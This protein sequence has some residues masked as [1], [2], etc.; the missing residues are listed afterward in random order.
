MTA[1]AIQA[2]IDAARTGPSDLVTWAELKA[3]LEGLKNQDAVYTFNSRQGTVLPLEGDY[4][5]NL[6]SDVTVSTP[7]TNQVLQ[8]NGTNWVNATSP[9]T[10]V[11]SVF[12]RT[13]AITSAEG[14]Y[15]LTQLS[16]VTISS[17][18][19]NQLLVYNGTIWTNAN[20][21]TL[22]T[23]IYSG[24]GQLA[25]NRIVDLNSY[26]LNFR[27]AGSPV[28]YVAAPIGGISYV[29]IQRSNPT[30]ELDVNGTI[31]SKGFANEGQSN[32]QYYTGNFV[33]GEFGCYNFTKF[34]PTT[35]R[36]NI[37]SYNLWTTVWYDLTTASYTTNL[38]DRYATAFLGQVLISGNAAT[39]ATQYIS[40]ATY[41]FESFNTSTP[42]NM[43][44]LR[45][46][47]IR[48]PKNGGI[49]GHTIDNVMGIKIAQIKGTSGYTITNGW[50]VYQEGSSDN[51]Y[52]N[53]KILVGTNTAGSS[54][55]RISGLPTSAAGLSIG[56][57]WNDSGTI[58]IA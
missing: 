34:T 35:V 46:I 45:H 44:E 54:P 29:G 3:I 9:A 5:L 37:S 24:D 58:K 28:I 38:S 14:D 23:T 33:N 30:A 1:A 19:L 27:S 52:F 18:A 57:L 8:Y 15:S 2:L 20:L 11:S 13:G 32:F 6:L 16:D 39:K 55:V 50:G 51:N 41:I 17:P 49:S 7:T 43:S 56:D 10:T 40:S 4:S 31:L 47:D 42:M 26:T 21:S 25:G 48:S 53:G 12:G 36:N 22:T